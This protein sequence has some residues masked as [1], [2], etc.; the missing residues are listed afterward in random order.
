MGRMRALGNWRS[1]RR[2]AR[3][4]QTES[5]KSGLYGQYYHQPTGP[6][7][8]LPALLRAICRAALYWVRSRRSRS[9]RARWAPASPCA[10]SR[11]C[12]AI[13]AVGCPRTRCGPRLA[14]SWVQRHCRSER[15]V[16][17]HQ[18]SDLPGFLIKGPYN[19]TLSPFSQRPLSP[20][21]RPLITRVFKAR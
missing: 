13:A 3:D 9:L 12:C 6:L 8:A 10:D 14:T 5:R 2:P 19:G 11:V 16:F 15:R 18:R 17:L 1:P 21:S 7:S 20:A 4:G